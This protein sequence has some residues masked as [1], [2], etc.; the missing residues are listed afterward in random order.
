VKDGY[1]ALSYL[2]G[3]LKY[4]NITYREA[5]SVQES[6]MGTGNVEMSSVDIPPVVVPQNLVT[7]LETCWEVRKVNDD[8]LGCTL[9]VRSKSGASSY[10]Y[11]NPMNAVFGLMN[12]LFLESCPHDSR[13]ALDQPDEF[14][15]YRGIFDEEDDADD[16]TPEHG[17][18]VNIV[19]VDGAEDL[20][21]A[22]VSR[23]RL[24]SPLPL[25]PCRPPFYVLRRGACLACCL[26]L[27]RKV[28]IQHLI[29]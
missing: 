23:R 4:D 26:K 10:G 21:M 19:A 7:D 15:T 20:R 29:L 13:A 22:A 17:S 12:G 14:A 16:E 11:L 25:E 18:R 8:R 6:Q 2:P 28:G 5:D 27:C 3:V 1:M 24:Q 9:K